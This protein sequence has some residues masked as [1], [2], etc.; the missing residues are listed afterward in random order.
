[1]SSN[2]KSKQNHDKIVVMT[3]DSSLSM[4]TVTNVNKQNLAESSNNCNGK[5]A[6][7]SP[8]RQS[9]K[10]QAAKYC[11]KKRKTVT[12]TEHEIDSSS[13]IVEEEESQSN[14]DL[15]Q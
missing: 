7:K 15:D 10:E 6:M 1:M 12:V 2:R 9:Q 4:V 14:V 5:R 11:N 3:D 8:K 13:N